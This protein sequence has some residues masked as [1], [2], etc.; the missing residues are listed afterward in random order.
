MVLT[1]S[2]TLKN[3][4]QP[5]LIEK[6]V[7]SQININEKKKVNFSTGSNLYYDPPNFADENMMKWE[8]IETKLS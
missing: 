6:K 4:T 7:D 1:L 3:A 2:N 5:T 8:T